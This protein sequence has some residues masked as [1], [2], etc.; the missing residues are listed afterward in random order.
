[1]SLIRASATI[2]GLTL[3]SRIF[4]FVRDMMIASLLGA[5]ILSDAFL[6][7]FKLPNFM[8]RLFAEGAFNS[9]FLPLYAQTLAGEGPDAARTL[10][11]EIHAVLVS[12]L[13]ILC[14]LA[15][16]FMPQLMVL[17][18]PGFDKDPAKFALSVTLTR[19]TFPY[20]LFISL[21]SLQG[22]LLNS[23]DKF[24]AVAA[25]PIIM[26]VCL[27]VAMLMVAPLTPT[28]AHALSIGVLVSGVAQYLWLFYYCRKAGISPRF[29]LPRFTRN[30]R[31]LFVAIGPAAL[32]SS[33]A[34]INLMI[35]VMIATWIPQAPSVLY[36][37]DRISELPLGVIGIAVSTALLPM[38]SRQIR[39]GEIAT[40]IHTQN[41]ALELSLFFGLPAAIALIVI[42]YPLITVMYERG[43]FTASD[44]IATFHTLIAYAVGLPAF[45][46]VKIFASTFYAN[47]DTRTPVKIAVAC[48]LINLFFNL[49]LMG[50]MQYVG[51]AL[52]TSIAGWVNAICLGYYLKKRGLFAL[53]TAFRF[54]LPR[55]I[56]ASLAMGTALYFAAIWLNP[57]F[58]ARLI[59]K[60]CALSGLIGVGFATY[61]AI[62]FLTGFMPPSQLR[63]YFQKKAV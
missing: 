5:G 45:L 9:A 15:V 46:L 32:G 24:A 58:H 26:N 33:V 44:T 1:M 8:R 23:I 36:Y 11:E 35:D 37:A 12:I 25:T 4:G 7:A 55:M 52:S 19:I 27:I 56:G 13:I 6:V 3:V 30:V 31:I 28:P 39:K 47:R 18:A 14:I 42:P 63:G 2:G 17:L 40:A 57:F 54:R 59:L 22:G 38:L 21:V 60:I 50:P 61:A 34:Q 48:V 10:A 16:I 51:L 49:T 62:L 29:R 43:A 53:D 41:R 20:I